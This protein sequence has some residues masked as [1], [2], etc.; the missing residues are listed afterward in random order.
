[1][2]SF[3]V[4]GG[5]DPDLGAPLYRRLGGAPAI[6]LFAV[7]LVSRAHADPLLREFFAGTNPIS[8]IEKLERFLSILTGGPGSWRG[9]SLSVAHAHLAITPE[10]FDRMMILV[11][12]VTSEMSLSGSLSVE[13]QGCLRVLELHIVNSASRPSLSS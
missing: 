4:S 7:A 11:A 10:D 3:Q 2:E 9:P 1:M 12:Q 5:Q 13:L 6:R 8:L